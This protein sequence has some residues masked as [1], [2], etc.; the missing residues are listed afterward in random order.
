LYSFLLLYTAIISHQLNADA[1]TD[2]NTRFQEANAAYSRN[3][4]ATAIENYEKLLAEDGYTPAALY[5]LG[6]SY[7]RAGKI[8]KAILNYERALKLNPGDSDILGNLLLVRNSNG[9]FEKKITFTEHLPGILNMNQWIALGMAAL[10]LLTCI[11]LISL[12]FQ[13]QQKTNA[14]ASI[15]CVLTIAVSICSSIALLRDWNSSIVIKR[16]ARLQISP[17][18]GAAAAGDI[19]EGR[20]VYPEK[21]HGEY[22]FVIDETGREGWILR[23]AVEPVVQ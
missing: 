10:L 21:A 14:L 6:N 1:G 16:D 13:L 23:S 9:L 22:F 19:M 12:R 18:E 3:D 8:G 4:T 20:K 5:N 17:F 7:A 11:Q 15:L 2:H